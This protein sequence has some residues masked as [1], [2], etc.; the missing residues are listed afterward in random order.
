MLFYKKE[1]PKSLGLEWVQEQVFPLIDSFK[2][3][4]DIIL[5][6][7]V[8]HIAIQLSNSLKDQ[9]EVLIT[10]GGVFNSFLITR[11]SFLS[12]VKITIPSEEIINY[13]EALIF[14]FLGLLRSDNQVNCLSSVTGANKDHSSGSIF[15]P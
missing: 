11:V 12:S 8:E 9:K 10:G 13:K 3:D 1:H 15:M 14:A 5:R 7:F 6:T 2:L 4:V